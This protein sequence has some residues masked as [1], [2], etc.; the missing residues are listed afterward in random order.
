MRFRRP[1]TPKEHER[2]ASSGYVPV[3]RSKVFLSVGLGQNGDVLHAWA[4]VKMSQY[5]SV[6]DLFDAMGT[7]KKE[8]E[9]YIGSTP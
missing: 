5:G 6:I 8:L 9:K 2:L 3:L 7:L 4:E 1:L